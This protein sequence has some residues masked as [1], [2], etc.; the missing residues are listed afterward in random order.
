VI[1]FVVSDYVEQV[2]ANVIGAEVARVVRADV[3]DELPQLTQVGL[4]RSAAVPFD[5][6]AVFD[7]LNPTLSHDPSLPMAGFS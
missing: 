1:R 3:L 7:S 4:D 6:H 2:G 5:F